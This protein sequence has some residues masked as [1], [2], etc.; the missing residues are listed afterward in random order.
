VFK[1]IKALIITT[2]PESVVEHI[3]STAVCCG[4]KNII[5]IMVVHKKDV[6]KTLLKLGFQ[7]GKSSKDNT[8]KVFV[9]SILFKQK[10]YNIHIHLMTPD[11]ISVKNMVH[12]RDF[13]KTHPAKIKQY[14]ALKKKAIVLKKVR[15]K[16][17]N[18]IKESFIR[19]IIG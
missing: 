8:R 10:H 15:N 6:S 13:L 12:L 14:E 7:K 4:G 19:K 2:I 1:K 11:H 9:G 16:E 5:D 3:G 18:P 17:Y